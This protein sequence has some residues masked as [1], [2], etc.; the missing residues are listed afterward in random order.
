MTGTEIKDLCQ[1]KG[2]S[3][4]PHHEC[5][6]CG[7]SVGWYLFGCWPPYEVAFSSACGC[8]DYSSARPDTWE[9]I[10]EWVCDPDGQL[11]ER[12]KALF[13]I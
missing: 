9:S 4:I 11:K 6:I 12:Y 3:F 8:S 7:E 13:A 10:A 2:I 1:A 5:A